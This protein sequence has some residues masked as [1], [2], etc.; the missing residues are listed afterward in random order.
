MSVS[1]FDPTRIVDNEP[2]IRQAINNIRTNYGDIVSVDAKKKSLIKFGRTLSANDG[3]RTTVGIFQDAVVNETFATTNSVDSI[4][5]TDAGDDMIITVEGHT[6]DTTNGKLT[7]V[8]Q[9]ATLN[10]QTRVALTTPMA[11][12]NR[13]YVKNGTYAS[14]AT[15]PSGNI[16]VYDNAANSGLTSGKPDTD[17]SVKL[18]LVAGINQT[19]KCATSISDDD[20]WIITEIYAACTRSA[21]Q[22]AAV[23]IEVEYRQIGGVWRPLGFEGNIDQGASSFIHDEMRPCHI[24]PKNSDVRM[25]AVSDTASTVV[26]GYI[27]GVL[28]KKVGT[29]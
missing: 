26:S 27:A 9:D 8:S 1:I 4:V 2:W 10:G 7:F 12:A 24:I 22:D 13:M 16:T 23:D 21:P 3:V 14:P 29:V 18:M 11:R 20:Y 25:I 19:E 6:I 28:A 17:A 15:A 5:S